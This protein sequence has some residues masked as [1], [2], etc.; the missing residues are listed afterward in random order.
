L[1]SNQAIDN[2]LLK[3]FNEYHQFW[4][5]GQ[6]DSSWIGFYQFM[7]TIGIKYDKRDSEL[8]EL[9]AQTAKS[10]SWF[11][12]FE[13]F[14]FVSDRPTKLSFDE[15]Y[16]LHDEHGPAYKYSD[17]WCGY[18]L[19]GVN[20]PKELYVKIISREMPMEEILKIVDIDQRT[21][22]MKFAKTGLRDFYK[23]QKGEMIDHYVKLDQK[24]R[25]INY[26]LWKIPPGE[27]F[28]K[29]V[30]FAIYNCPS[31]VERNE[32]KE[33]SKGVPAFK[34]VPEALAWGMSDDK[35]L[36]TPEEWKSL[37]PLLHES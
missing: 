21:Q 10:C 3:E 31:G 22:A 1:E 18:Y 13:N 19:H 23:S 4:A 17:G 36:I 26:E 8:L 25:P 2:K 29:T 28:N 32:N 7:E 6:M 11:W 37:V 5:Y 14:V 34:T 20:F 15:E 12:T 24:G 9:W 35:H 30:H 33:Y 16:R 27:I